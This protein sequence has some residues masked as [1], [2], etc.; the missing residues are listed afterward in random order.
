MHYISYIKYYKSFQQTEIGK[1]N[2]QKKV[3]FLGE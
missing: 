2:M 1:L 3:T